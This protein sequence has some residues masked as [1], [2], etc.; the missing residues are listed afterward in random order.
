MNNDGLIEK[1]QIN[2]DISCESIGLVLKFIHHIIQLKNE[3][4]IML[5]PEI[6]KQVL[7]WSE[8]LDLHQ[9]ALTVLLT[10]VISV[11]THSHS[12][13]QN[14]ETIIH[15]KLEECLN[16]SKMRYVGI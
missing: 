11:R 7:R 12:M 9:P 3:D 4:L 6:I 1:F 13:D 8:L 15:S 16:V 2:R 5:Y 10:I 14:F